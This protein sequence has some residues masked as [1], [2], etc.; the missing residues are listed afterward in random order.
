[1]HYNL[2]IYLASRIEPEAEDL[3][4]RYGAVPSESWVQFYMCNHE[5]QHFRQP[6]ARAF[7]VLITVWLLTAFG[8]VAQFGR[9]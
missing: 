4:S 3:R 1:M 6:I 5:F 9:A 7:V 2:L 8:I